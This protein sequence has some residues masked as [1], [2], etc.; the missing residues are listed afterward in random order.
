MSWKVYCLIFKAV[1]TFQ[2]QST[3]QQWVSPCPW[4]WPSL[5]RC[6]RRW[7][8]SSTSSRTRT[9]GSPTSSW[10]LAAAPWTWAVLRGKIWFIQVTLTATRYRIWEP[11]SVEFHSFNSLE[12]PVV[13][14][15]LPSGALLCLLHP[16]AGLD[17][18]DNLDNV[19][20]LDNLDS[21]DKLDNLDSLTKCS[22]SRENCSSCLHGKD[23]FS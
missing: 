14:E 4:G 7:G 2:K 19:G 9:A 6:P 3:F 20:N 23:L 11:D 17:S 8:G 22:K 15:H 13:V 5:W 12:L 21:L 18:L 10:C 1:V 16:K